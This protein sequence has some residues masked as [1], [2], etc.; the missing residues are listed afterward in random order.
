MPSRGRDWTMAVTAADGDPISP[1]V[2]L[3][4]SMTAD[5]GLEFAPTAVE[6]GA[7]GGGMAGG[8]GGGFGVPCFRGDLDFVLLLL[9]FRGV[10]E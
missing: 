5:D 1:R 2:M 7:G 4:E 3:D 6:E 10:E 9:L 8:G